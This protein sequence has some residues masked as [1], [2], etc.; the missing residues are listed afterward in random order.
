YF[1]LSTEVGKPRYLFEETVRRRD[2]T[3]FFLQQ[4]RVKTSQFE[5]IAAEEV[6]D[7][8]SLVPLHDSITLSKGEKVY[9]IEELS[10]EVDWQEQ[11][12][13][14]VVSF[15]FKTDTVVIV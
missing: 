15:E 5:V 2:G 13:R 8:I 9:D 12:D 6:I 11:G 3:N 14:A 7:A 10:M 4:I 1:L